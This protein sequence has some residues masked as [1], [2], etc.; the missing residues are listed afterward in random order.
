MPVSFRVDADGFQACVAQG[1]RESGVSATDTDC[2]NF[3]ASEFDR[4][5][6]AHDFVVLAWWI[7]GWL[8]FGDLWQLLA[9]LPD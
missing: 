3:S 7:G 6:E 4:H 1:G 5:F 2:A 9:F 8:M